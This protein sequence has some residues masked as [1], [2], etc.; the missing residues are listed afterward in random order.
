MLLKGVFNADSCS[1]YPEL[2]PSLEQELSF[3]H[4]R[5]GK[6]FN[7]LDECRILF[8]S[9]VP[10]VRMVF[11]QEEQLSRILYFNHQQVLIR[12]KDIYLTLGE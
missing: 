6:K 10:E 5:F 2:E 4:N 11:T 1:E 12:L 3:F 8:Q 7:S 9:F